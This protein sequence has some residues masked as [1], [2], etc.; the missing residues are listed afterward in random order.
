M[1]TD[2]NYTYS[3]LVIPTIVKSLCFTPK[4]SITLCINYISIKK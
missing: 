2:S 4:T 1:L 3:D